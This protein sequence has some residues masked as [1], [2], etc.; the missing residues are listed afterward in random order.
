[1]AEVVYVTESFNGETRAFWN[2]EEALHFVLREYA[3]FLKTS[4]Y[5]DNERFHL[6]V[7]AIDQLDEA[8]GVTDFGYVVMAELN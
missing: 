7:E 6:L 5:T 1:M 2:R 3:E 4:P 8:S